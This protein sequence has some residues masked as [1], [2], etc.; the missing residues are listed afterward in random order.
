MPTDQ[1]YLDGAWQASDASGPEAFLDV[2]NAFTEEVMA[3]VPAGTASDAERAVAAARRAFDGWATTPIADRQALLR[4]LANGLA[5]RQDEL[6][7]LIAQEVG[8]PRMLAKT[9]QAGLPIGTLRAMADLLDTFEME[10]EV[11]S[12]LVLR[13]PIGVVAAITPWNYPLHQIVGK[14][15]PALAAGCT[16]ALKPS[17]VAPLNAFVLAE[18]CH[19]SG[20]PPGVFNLVTGLGSVVG[21]ALAGHPDVDMVSFT[22]S[23][24][25]GVRVAQLAAATVKRVTL[26]LGGKSANLLLDDADLPRAVRSGVNH[27][28][29]NS[30]QTCSAWTRLLVPRSL[31]E[32]A[33]AHARTTAERFTL[34]DPLSPATKLGPLVSAAQRERVVAYIERGI[35]EGARLV[36]GG[37]ERPE[38]LERGYFVRPT[39]FADVDNTMAIARE[40]IFGPVLAI[41]PYDSEDEAIAIAND[42][43]YGLSGGVWSQDA[44]RAERVARRLRTGQVDLNGGRYNPLAPFGGYKQSGNGREF[45]RWGLEE[46]LET[47]SLQ[48]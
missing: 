20:L 21:E 11:G 32:E 4:R 10:Q 39:I 8:M 40:E 14:L 25:A 6:A 9:L 24:R 28:F 2:H 12:S 13:E 18:V 15:A 29:L 43:P 36:T 31:Q 38:G 46:Y 45:G 44:A 1:L 17:E 35:A 26:E 22:G 19:D 41:L 42:S 37:P 27:C 30:G 5:A 34:G 48:R 16:V 3:R 33:I 7:T 23:T 47:K